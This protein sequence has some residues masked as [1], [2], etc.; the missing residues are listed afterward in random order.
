MTDN[1]ICSLLGLA[2][3]AGKLA[4][5]DEPVRELLQSGVIRL[6]LLASDAGA[7]STRQ[8]A[9]AAG[10]AK[11]PLLTLPVDKETLG[12]ALGRKTCAVC[13]LSDSGFASKA[14]EK[15]AA[16][17]P[18]LCPA[19]ETLA[20]QH[21]RFQ[22]RRGIKKHRSPEAQPSAPHRTAKPRT[23]RPR[24]SGNTEPGR[25]QPPAAGHSRPG[26]RRPSKAGANPRR[27]RPAARQNTRTGIRNK[28]QKPA[29]SSG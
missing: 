14:A 23:N 12:G 21:A 28:Q 13:A 24:K 27:N 15:L 18:S 19:A 9:F 20:K 29:G 2:K 11:A 8:A 25:S 7:A 4:A 3:R 17:D 5:G 1:G 16:L 22:S 26:A 6:V 10:R